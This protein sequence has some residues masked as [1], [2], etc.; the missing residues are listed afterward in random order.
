MLQTDEGEVTL[1]GQDPR[2]VEESGRIP[3]GIGHAEVGYVW[4]RGEAEGDLQH[5]LLDA[6]TTGSRCPGDQ[7]MGSGVV[8]LVDHVGSV[9]DEGL[10]PVLGPGILGLFPVAAFRRWMPGLVVVLLLEGG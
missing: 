9:V 10:A 3:T 2:L 1:R 8:A 6:V 7:T 4:R 5:I